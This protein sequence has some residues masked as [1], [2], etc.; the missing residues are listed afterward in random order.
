MQ[1]RCISVWTVSAHT[2]VVAD[3]GVHGICASANSFLQPCAG[4][5]KV[6]VVLAAAMWNCPH[7]LVLVRCRPPC[8]SR[9][10]P[11]LRDWQQASMQQQMSTPLL[12]LL[13]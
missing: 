6:K 9:H 7:L 3:R 4:G 12:S 13:E 11:S 1:M 2:R 8:T 5:Q 10:L